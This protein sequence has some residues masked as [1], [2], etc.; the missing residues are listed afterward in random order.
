VHCEIIAIGQGEGK[1]LQSEG[2]GAMLAIVS[3]VG[4]SWEKGVPTVDGS[5]LTC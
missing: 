1:P 2:C 3:E 4:A 5:R